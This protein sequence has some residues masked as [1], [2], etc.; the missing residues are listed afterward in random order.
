MAVHLEIENVGLGPEQEIYARKLTAQLGQVNIKW[1]G[2]VGRKPVIK[3][4][5][6][7]TPV[8]EIAILEVF[9]ANHTL[10]VTS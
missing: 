3:A 5:G 8:I 9:G 1:K 7:A 10:L 6:C 4:R 2:G